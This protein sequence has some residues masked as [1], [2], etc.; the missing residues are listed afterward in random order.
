M[1]GRC[2]GIQQR[3]QLLSIDRDQVGGIFGQ[4]RVR[5]AKTAATGSPT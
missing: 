5:V 3:L 4:A 2:P 1:S